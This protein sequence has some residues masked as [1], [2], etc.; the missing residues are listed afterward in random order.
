MTNTLCGRVT[1]FFSW[2]ISLTSMNTASKPSIKRRMA[3]QKE[4]KKKSAP[5]VLLAVA[6]KPSARVGRGRG[7]VL[8]LPTT[9]R[10]TRVLPNTSGVTVVAT[11]RN[12]TLSVTQKPFRS[13]RREKLMLPGIGTPLVGDSSV[14]KGYNTKCGPGTVTGDDGKC[15]PATP[16]NVLE[17][18]A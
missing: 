14:V 11:R 8:S 12:N 7:R 5:S 4:Q 13:R 1:V 6:S 15:V 16:S 3:Q 18:S 17:C 9:R 10:N 2:Y